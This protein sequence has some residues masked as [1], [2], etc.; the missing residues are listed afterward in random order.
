MYMQHNGL[1]QAVKIAERCA[2][3]SS[4]FFSLILFS[5]YSLY[6]VV[7]VIIVILQ[8]ETV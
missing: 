7:V 6:A 8:L 2:R 4:V 5:F 3:I 1:K